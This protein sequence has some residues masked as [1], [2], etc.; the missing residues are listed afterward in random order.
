MKATKINP[1]DALLEIIH[2]FQKVQDAWNHLEK[3][4]DEIQAQQRE[5]ISERRLA[6]FNALEQLDRITTILQN[7]KLALSVKINKGSYSILGTVPY[8]DG[9]ELDY[10]LPNGAAYY[11]PTTK[12]FSFEL[13]S[14]KSAIHVS[15]IKAFKTWLDE[16]YSRY[17]MRNGEDAVRWACA[18]SIDEEVE[19]AQTWGDLF[20]NGENDEEKFR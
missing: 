14:E 19:A 4:S 6:I 13:L 5:W 20:I 12:E 17:P 1:Q 10:V 7:S 11:K 2:E 18:S 15:E 3:P 9:A 8:M 16:I